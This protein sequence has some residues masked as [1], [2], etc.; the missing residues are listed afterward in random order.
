MRMLNLKKLAV[1]SRLAGNCVEL[2]LSLMALEGNDYKG[3]LAVVD[4]TVKASSLYECVSDLTRKPRQCMRRLSKMT[5][6]PM[7]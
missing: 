1:V 3:L 4:K 6:Q 5:Q 2:S 7:L